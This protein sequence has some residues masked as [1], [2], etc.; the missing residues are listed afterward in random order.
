MVSTWRTRTSTTSFA[1]PCHLAAS[2][3]NLEIAQI[4]LKNGADLTSKDKEGFSPLHWAALENDNTEML[5]LLL[6]KGANI[7]TTDDVMLTPFYVAAKP[8]VLPN[9][10]F[11]LDQGVDLNIRDS[12]G[13]SVLQY[14]VK[15]QNNMKWS[16]WSKTDSVLTSKTTKISLRKIP[17]GKWRENWRKKQRWPTLQGSQDEKQHGRGAGSAAEWG[18]CEYPWQK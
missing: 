8:Q 11:L 14:A 16:F 3:K 4:L 18:R 17:V 10:K 13:E 5:Q 7:N 2:K 9:I 1:R 12:S 6:E 15:S